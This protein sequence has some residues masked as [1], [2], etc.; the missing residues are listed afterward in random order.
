MRRA[1][2][3]TR[4]YITLAT[5]GSR[6]VG[7]LHNGFL[8]LTQRLNHGSCRPDVR[9]RA[10][11]REDSPA[12]YETKTNEG[13]LNMGNKDAEGHFYD[14]GAAEANTAA[15]VQTRR[16]QLIGPQ[17]PNIRGSE[18]SRKHFGCSQRQEVI[19]TSP[20]VRKVHRIIGELFCCSRE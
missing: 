16:A 4:V 12:L 19:A 1:R 8:A 11:L 20:P 7:L 5:Q 18:A 2:G 17:K 3:T 9:E 10:T 6:H 15:Q 13:V 14:K